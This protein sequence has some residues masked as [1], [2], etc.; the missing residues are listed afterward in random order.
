MKRRL[1]R[2]LVIASI[3][4]LPFAFAAPANAFCDESEGCSP[5]PPPTVTVDKEHGVQIIWIYC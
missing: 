2:V 5:C 1:A 4:V 3:A